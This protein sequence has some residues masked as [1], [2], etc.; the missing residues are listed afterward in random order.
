MINNFEPFVIALELTRICKMNCI[1]CRANARPISYKNEL[2]TKECFEI[3]DDISK[4]YNPIIVLTGG[5]P[6]EREDIFQIAEHGAKLGLYISTTACGHSY[7]EENLQ[8]LKDAGVLRITMSLNGATKKTH[9]EISG[10]DGSFDEVMRSIEVC[11]KVDISFHINTTV[12]KRNVKEIPLILELV[13]KVGSLGYYPFFFVPMGRGSN[14]ADQSIPV[15]E[16]EKLLNSLYDER[17][18][19]NMHYKK[20]DFSFLDEF[21]LRPACAPQFRRIVTQRNEELKTSNQTDL[22]FEKSFKGCMGGILFA[23]ISHIGKVQPCGMLE[24]ECGDTRKEPFSKIWKTSKFFQDLRDVSKYKGKCEVCSY[25]QICGGC[26]ARAYVRTGD[27]L[28]E[29]TYCLYKPEKS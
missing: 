4:H 1:F 27:Y 11:K 21:V 13:K 10:R 3:L 18:K 25:L 26:R 15:E 28:E 6:M 2:T 12:V 19:L 7:N 22:S 17:L 24:I 9:D 20:D 16:Y 8:R 5:D 14:S 29:D 23:F